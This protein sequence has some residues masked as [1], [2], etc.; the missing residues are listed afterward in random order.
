MVKN[1]FY[2]LASWGGGGGGKIVPLMHVALLNIHTDLSRWARDLNFKLSLH[3][4]VHLH[5]VYV[6]CEGSGESA[7]LHRLVLTFAACHCDKYQNT[8]KPVLSGHSK[9]KTKN[10]FSLPIIT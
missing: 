1:N 2:I 8:V 3:L 10:W 5:L 9:K 7:Y 6:S 4:Y